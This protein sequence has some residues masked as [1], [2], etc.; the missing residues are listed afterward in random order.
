MLLERR[1]ANRFP[2]REELRYRVINSRTDKTSGSGRTF[3]MSSSGILFSTQG[4]LAPG[5]TV[6]VSINWPAQIDDSCALKLVA[7]GR[8]IRSEIDR[9]AVKIE[10]YEFRTR[11]PEKKHGR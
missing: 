10:R 9:A 11:K 3:D 7:G 1:K 5:K 8:V 4:P 2:L 6:E